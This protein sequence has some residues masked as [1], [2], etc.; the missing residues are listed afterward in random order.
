MSN[1]P[2]IVTRA[3]SMQYGALRAL[4]SLDLE[5]PRGTLFG[6]L[7]PNGA[8]KSTTIAILTT[9]LTPSSGQASVAGWDVA[10]NPRQVRASLGVVFQE[11]SLDGRLT[12]Y[13]NLDLFAAMYGIERR[14]RPGRIAA[15]RSRFW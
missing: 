13:Q 12:A 14:L 15:K 1:Q 9:L 8:G 2:A 6:L 7:G 10:R 5:V 3:L 4:D 11:V